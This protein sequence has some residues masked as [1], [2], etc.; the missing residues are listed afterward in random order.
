MNIEFPHLD[1]TKFPG[2]NNEDTLSGVD[3]YKYQN[4]FNYYRW[5]NQVS[6][7]LLNVLW[8]SN[9]ADVPYFETDNLRDKWFDE[10]EGIIQ[11]PL[12][13]FNST[14]ETNI[15][16]PLPYNDAYKYNYVVVDMP[17]QTSSNEPLDYENENSRVKRWYYFIEDTIQLSP[18]TTQFVL[19]V[20]YWT[21]FIH[22]VE[23]NY[24]MLERG[25]APMTKVSVDDYLENPL[26]NSEY[27]LADDFNYQRGESI[28][29]ASSYTPIG[30]GTKYVL[31][32]APIKQADFALFG[33]V[34]L[35]GNSTPPRYTDTSDRYGYQLTVH[36]YEWKYG[37][38]NYSDANLPVRGTLGQDNLVFNGCYV[39][40]IRADEAEDFFNL[41]A[42]Y[43]VHFIHAIQAVFVLDESMFNRGES[44]TFMS[45]TIYQC[46]KNQFTQNFTFTKNAFGFDSKYKE[47]AKLYTSPYSF[48]EFTD[49]NGNTFN[50]NIENCGSSF[51]MHR[52]VALTF[53]FIRY[54]IFLTGVNGSGQ[55]N[56]TWKNLNDS[57]VSKTMWES[58]FAK[59]MMNWDIPIYS[60]YVSSE[61]EFA[62]NNAADIQN[63][64][65]KAIKDYQ[66]CTRLA[67]TARENM[68]D[69][70]QTNTDNVAATGQTQND[71]QATANDAKRDITGSAANDDVDT[72]G[73]YSG[74][75]A[76]REIQVTNNL[77]NSEITSLNIDKL[78]DDYVTD[79]RLLWHT[80]VTNNEYA[81]ISGFVNMAATAVTGAASISASAASGAQAGAT[82]GPAGAAAGAISQGEA[83]V[84]N[85]GVNV[86]ATGAATI[87][88][89]AN[90]MDITSIAAQANTEKTQH[91]TDN[92]RDVNTKIRDNSRDVTHI[93]NKV[94][95]Y[96][97]RT[98]IAAD[99]EITDRTVTTNNANAT[100]TQTTETN[101]A[102]YLRN[103]NHINYDADL[104]Q[105][106][107][108]AET[109]YK[110]NRLR[111]PV[112]ATQSGG[113]AF[114]DIW[115]RRGVR[116]NIRTQTEAAIKQAGDAFLRFGYALHR[117]W[118]MSQG[119]NYMKHFTFWKAEDIWINDGSGV[120]NIATNTIGDILLK[121]VTV[122]KNPS[123]IGMVSIYDN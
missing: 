80:A 59:Y 25:H 35:S 36:D 79:N 30:N 19:R 98:S 47:I 95:R 11:L 55:F 104:K 32:A 101:N 118:D 69:S 17:L 48:L 52:E 39:Y 91:A 22:S 4:D 119:F 56:Y 20:D 34:T 123:E 9:Y 16:L 114:P 100:R 102:T 90:S 76:N 77:T 27:L 83:N 121:G 38:V 96:T 117:V 110:N 71:N 87:I 45:Q 49:D 66:N 94:L 84:I 58:D 113:D 122:W 13:P 62:A 10:Q 65:A 53:P 12:T 82:G 116:L 64:R 68:A 72:I 14:P 31:F 42:K 81:A 93:T 74:D 37:E 75:G 120:A 15:Q 109:L 63:K 115:Q 99:T 44:F 8:N 61:A 2:V 97:A 23:I 21:T 89:I 86:I 88:G 111:K 1:D 33:G 6:V 112:I 5:R 51:Q 46:Y 24:L 57:N 18:S 3:V 50:I 43:R 105:A 60:L 7:K 26:E 103:V 85:T 108:D 106:Q 70:M 29:R 78:S 41:M 92:M 40:A 67:N 107:K 54:N 28:I 73:T